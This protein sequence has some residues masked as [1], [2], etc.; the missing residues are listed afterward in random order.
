[1]NTYLRAG[2]VVA[3]SE[4]CSPTERPAGWGY[5][6]YELCWTPIPDI[7]SCQDLKV[8]VPPI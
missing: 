6:S 5:I 1:M 4:T 7:D 3:E 8:P 2:Q